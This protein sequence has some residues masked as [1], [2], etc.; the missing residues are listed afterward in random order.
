M[1]DDEFD[2]LSPAEKLRIEINNIWN[3]QGNAYAYRYH[4]TTPEGLVFFQAYAMVRPEPGKAQSL[5]QID[6]FVPVVTLTEQAAGAL[7]EIGFKQIG[8]IDN[9]YTDVLGTCHDYPKDVFD[10]F[11]LIIVRY[12]QLDYITPEQVEECHALWWTQS[13][14][15]LSQMTE[16]KKDI[17]RYMPDASYD[18]SD[19]SKRRSPDLS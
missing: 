14:V 11:S 6:Y 16:L 10:E 19:A 3:D 12:K 7:N 15:L 8:F 2:L 18:G 13:A 9:H 17:L 1:T 4:G 5:Q